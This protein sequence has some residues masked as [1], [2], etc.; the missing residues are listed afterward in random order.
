MR[1][2]T[3]FRIGTLTPLSLLG[4]RGLRRDKCDNELDGGRKLHIF[5]GQVL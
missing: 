3:A 4:I 1:S 5:N 2:R